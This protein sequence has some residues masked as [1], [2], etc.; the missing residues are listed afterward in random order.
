M[1]WWS[2]FEAICRTDAPLRE[3]TWYRLGGAA[4]WLVEPRS[5]SE[6]VAVAAR[7][8]DAGIEFRVLGQGANVLVC[9]EGYPG[10]VLRLVGAEFE[11]VTFEP[12][13][14]VAGAGAD[15]PRLIR[16]ALRQGLVGLEILAG[17]PG[18]VGGTVR[19]NAGGK[20]GETGA[21]VREARVLES[22]GT[23]RTRSREQIGFGYRVTKLAGAV[24]LSVVYELEPGDA[25]A[26][27]QRHREIWNEKYAT[28]PALAQRSAG[29]IFKNPPGRAAGRLLDEA[30]LKGVRVG[31]AEIS[32]RHANFIVAHEGARASDVLDLIALARDRVWNRTGIQ[33][34]TEIE[35]WG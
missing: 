26:A 21:L 33:L 14:V 2:G 25:D 3:H 27:T 6:L 15:L 12:P 16:A 18:S 19:M 30:G 13:H 23:V 28:Q 35:I 17:I 32:P 11:Q 34:E 22:D 10:A 8:R 24:V 20:Y 4:R 9:D 31:G 7:L 29:C 5:A 1:S